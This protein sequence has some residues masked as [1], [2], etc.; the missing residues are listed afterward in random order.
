MRFLRNIVYSFG[1]QLLMVH[2]KKHQIYLLVWLVLFLSITGVFGKTYGIPYLFIDPEYLGKVNFWS[3]LINGA[4]LGLL[5][6]TFHVA[7]YTLN[8]FRFPFLATLRAPFLVFIINN[9]FLPLAFIVTYCVAIYRF[10]T[11]SV[12]LP[13]EKS[14]VFILALLLGLAI[15]VFTFM[16]YFLRLNDNIKS[17]IIRKRKKGIE[18]FETNTAKRR[19][20]WEKVQKV[21]K[22]W[23]V[24]NYLTRHLSVRL[25]RGVEHYSEELLLSV[26]RQHHFNAFILQ[27]LM[28]V[29]ILFLGSMMD[30]DYF[31]IP[32]GASMMLLFSAGMMLLGA[33]SYWTRGWRTFSFIILILIISLV[34]QSGLLNTQSRVAGMIY[35]GLCPECTEQTVRQHANLEFVNQDKKYTLQILE[36]WK[37]KNIQEYRTGH[38]PKMIFIAASGGGHRA[39]LWTL[40]TL[41]QLDDEFQ[42]RFMQQTI[43]MT[44]ASGG[45]IGSAYF[46]ELY[47]KRVQGDSI[48]LQDKKYLDNISRDL[49]NPVVFAIASN[50][51][52]FPWR[53]YKS[54]LEYYKKDR[55]YLFEKYLNHNTGHLMNKKLKEYKWPEYNMEIP[56]LILAPTIITD[57]RKMYISPQPVRYLTR[58][59]SDSVTFNK[60]G[61]DGIDFGTFFE[62][63]NS[64][65]ITLTTALRLN[66]TYPYILPNSVLPS[67]NRVEVM[68]AGIR[69]NFG[70]ETI[71]RFTHVF[72]DWIKENTDGIIIIN[73]NSVNLESRELK[74]MN[75]N[76]MA[77]LFNPI[78]NLY[79][80]WTI[81]QQYNQNASIVMMN[82]IMGGQLDY[83]E[84]NYTPG[85]KN[86]KAA[87][88]SFHL[89]AR[90]KTNI[91]QS[92]EYPENQAAL[93]Q[94][95]NALSNRPER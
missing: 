63:N 43:L 13:P 89:N 67:A 90:E 92:F 86:E 8:S 42:S 78:G 1:I 59:G 27:V 91:I 22:I 88:M 77:R 61:I 58:P 87:S 64:Y 3:F 70:I 55:G 60:Q 53:K 29:L 94:L 39:S 76:L 28:I 21:S 52:F 62:A 50:D 35:S 10:H 41:Q 79:D 40:K 25:V 26:F 81:I 82:D 75:S 18:F 14:L 47:Y 49:L 19:L 66:A 46:R 23:P 45:L 93:L 57:E 68:D 69:D 48:D 24:E 12:G 17:M 7:S 16:T 54:G 51:V 32:A 11:L 44:G 72:K 2:L 84:F 36:N 5:I 30:N 80:N 33:F 65:D 37:K 20:E 95:R 74:P 15:V 85:D 9:G 38:K 6:M 73:I 31:I 83:I 34:I 56:M 71:L 4:A